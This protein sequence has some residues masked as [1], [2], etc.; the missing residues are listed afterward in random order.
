[1]SSVLRAF[2]NKYFYM[3][4]SRFNTFRNRLGYYYSISPLLILLQKY[5]GEK[6]SEWLERFHQV[7]C[8]TLLLRQS[9]AKLNQ[10]LILGGTYIMR[11]IQMLH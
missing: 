11:A 7:S 3:V 5:G 10:T 6:T 4:M 9:N 8:K 2:K 1:M